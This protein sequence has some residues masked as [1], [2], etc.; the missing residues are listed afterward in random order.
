M[1]VNGKLYDWESVGISLPSGEAVGISEINYSDERPVEERFGKGSVARGY[2]RKNYKASGSM[3]LDRDE[4]DRL[5]DAL[6]GSFYDGKPFPI[7][8]EYANEDQP[9]ITDVLPG[10][11]IT[12]VDTSAKQDEDNAGQMKFDFKILSPIKWNQKEAYGIAVGISVLLS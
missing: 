1:S 12:K 10:C 2:G 4:A 11:K 3:T 7:T 8:V 5:L 9:G 6:G